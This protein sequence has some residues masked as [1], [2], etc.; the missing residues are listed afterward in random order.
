[1]IY[2]IIN[3]KEHYPMLK[4]DSFLHIY[5]PNNYKEFSEGRKRK[6]ILILPGGGYDY[7]S[8]RE[9][10]PV[11]FQFVAKGFVSCV[12]FYNCA[13][14]EYPYPF[15]EGY[16]AVAYLRK[17]ANEYNI[18][19]NKIIIS[20]FSA[21]G[22]MAAT[23]ACYH[24]EQE[25]A[26]YIN[27]SLG[28]IKING[29]VLSYP[30]ISTDINISHPGTVKNAT[31]GKAELIDKLSI[32][33]H[34]NADFPKCYLWHTVDDGAVPIQGTIALAKAF[35]DNHVFFEYHAFPKGVHGMSIASKE[36]CYFSDENGWF[37]RQD[38]EYDSRWI[39]E[40]IHF[41]DKYI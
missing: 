3:L 19:P 17:H 6:T 30:V 26:D 24:R 12:L 18:D 9:G 16:A 34:V 13:P 38:C 22:H 11:V 8:F 1:M 15:V 40:S 29:A 2:K 20:G 14:F 32:D 21:G 5:A 10:E 25:F 37:D 41:I 23:L 27:E 31:Q 4:K 33:K 35:V 7:T 39:E 28:S 36:V